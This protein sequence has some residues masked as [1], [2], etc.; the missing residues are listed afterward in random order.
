MISNPGLHLVNGR[1]HVSL[2]SA[3]APPTALKP[4]CELQELSQHE[5]VM[6]KV[7]DGSSRPTESVREKPCC[8]KMAGG[9]QQ[10]TTQTLR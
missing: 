4:G 8:Y 2:L 10:T 5:I 9:I 6:G 3:F 1:L 7:H